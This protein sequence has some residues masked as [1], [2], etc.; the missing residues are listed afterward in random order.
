MEECP[1]L[2]TTGPGEVPRVLEYVGIEFLEAEFQLLGNPWVHNPEFWDNGINVGSSIA[3][4]GDDIVRESSG[5][6]GAHIWLDRRVGNMI[7]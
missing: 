6:S 4:R 3:T 2:N 5:S 1:G 7:Y